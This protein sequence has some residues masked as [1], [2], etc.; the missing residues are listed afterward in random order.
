MKRCRKMFVTVF[1][2]N[3]GVA[4]APQCYINTNIVSLV[5]IILFQ[6]LYSG[7][8][9]LFRMYSTYR[10]IVLKC[11]RVLCVRDNTVIVCTVVFA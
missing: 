5:E 1:Y 11:S 4:N 7:W 8:R 9:P 10:Y 3:C 6:I 2:G